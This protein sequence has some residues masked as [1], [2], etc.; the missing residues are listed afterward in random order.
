MDEPIRKQGIRFFFS[1]RIAVG[2]VMFSR[3]HNSALSIISVG[4]VGD[5]ILVYAIL[6]SRPFNLSIIT[7]KGLSIK[8]IYSLLHYCIEQIFQLLLATLKRLV[9]LVVFVENS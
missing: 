1:H 7:S 5:T 2:S 4:G 6:L 3:L 9:T 8:N